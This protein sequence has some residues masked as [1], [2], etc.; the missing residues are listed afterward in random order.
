MKAYIRFL[1]NQFSRDLKNQT[2]QLTFLFV[3]LMFL[4]ILHEYPDLL[5][6]TYVVIYPI[7]YIVINSIRYFYGKSKNKQAANE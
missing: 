6:L 7:S 4:L 3:V 1:V 5:V 2:K